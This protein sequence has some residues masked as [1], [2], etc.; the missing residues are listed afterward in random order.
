MSAFKFPKLSKPTKVK[1]WEKV[2]L[3][4]VKPIV[5]NDDITTLII[6]KMFGKTYIINHYLNPSLHPDRRLWID[7][8]DIKI[9]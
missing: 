5:S 3:F 2:C 6:K 8:N 4:F 1:S 7:A 9:K